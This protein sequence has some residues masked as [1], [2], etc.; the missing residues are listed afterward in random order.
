MHYLF[1]AR[2]LYSWCRSCQSP[3]KLVKKLLGLGLDNVVRNSFWGIPKGI[4]IQS[5]EWVLKERYDGTNCP[6]SIVPY[7]GAQGCLE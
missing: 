1:I 2:A 6:T 5:R 3:F 7:L 4:V